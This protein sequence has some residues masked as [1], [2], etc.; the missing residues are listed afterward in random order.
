MRPDTFGFA[1][2][3][4]SHATLKHIGLLAALDAL[5]VYGLVCRTGTLHHQGVLYAWDMLHLRGV[6]GIAARFQ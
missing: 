6:L 1:G 2:L 3:L 4:S 5:V